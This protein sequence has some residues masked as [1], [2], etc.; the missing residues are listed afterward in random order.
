MEYKCE[1]HTHK[2]IYIPKHETWQ[3]ND[4][5]RNLVE[6]STMVSLFIILWIFFIVNKFLYQ[7]FLED[8]KFIQ[9]FHIVVLIQHFLRRFEFMAVKNTLN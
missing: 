5:N 6:V 2:L 8:F 9:N 7:D 1:T 3:R 4:I